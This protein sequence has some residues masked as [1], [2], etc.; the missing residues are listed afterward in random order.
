MD[1][2]FFFLMHYLH[3]TGAWLSTHTVF[4]SSFKARVPVAVQSLDPHPQPRNEF[5]CETVKLFFLKNIFRFANVSCAALVFF[6]L[7]DFNKNKNKNHMIRTSIFTSHSQSSH[8]FW[9]W[10]WCH[11]KV[12][13]NQLKCVFFFS[14]A[15]L[16][17]LHS[18]LGDS[19]FFD[20]VLC[21]EC[22]VSFVYDEMAVFF[23]F[24]AQKRKHK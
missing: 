15:L 11:W 5:A 23:L 12:N 24:W 9:I 1:I 16:S 4:F 19:Q 8:H 3:H 17:S 18:L 10:Y 6:S 20:R 7:F 14:F 13:L 22:S 2:K 21:I